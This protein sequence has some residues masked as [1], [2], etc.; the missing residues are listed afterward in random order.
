MQKSEF[1]NLKKN[2]FIDSFASIEKAMK[3]YNSDP[4]VCCSLFRK[5]LES[6]IVDV[7]SLFGGSIEGH[8]KRDIDNLDEV[9]P[10]AFLKTILLWN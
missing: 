8:N 5:A 2:G 3:Y 7:Y 9:I 4:I 10:D 1:I 6:I